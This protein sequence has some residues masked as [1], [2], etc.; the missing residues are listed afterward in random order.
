VASDR[1]AMPSDESGTT[2]SGVTAF[3][4]PSSTLGPVQPPGEAGPVDVTFTVHADRDAHPISPL[5]Y[6]TSDGRDGELQRW[7]VVRSGGNRLTAYNWEN[8]ASNAG[9]DYQFQNDS[10]MSVSDAPGRSLLDCIEVAARAGAPSI[11]TL[12]IGDYV[13]AD[14]NGG[15]DVRQAGPNYLA[16]RFKRNHAKKP[17][18]FAPT[19]NTTDGDVYQ[20]EAVAFLKRQR[21]EAKVIFA[22]DNEPD[23]WA[24]THAEVFPEPVTYADLWRRNHEF[25]KATK[26]AWPGVEVLGLVSYGYTGYIS[27]QNAPDAGGRNFLEWYLDQAKAAEAKDGRRLIDYLDLHWYPEAMG[28]GKRIVGDGVEPEVAEARVQAPRSLWDPTY[29]EASWIHDVVG[30]PVE[31]IPWIKKKIDGHYPDTKLAFTEWNFGGGSHISG[32][33]AT[34]D[35]LGVFGQQGVGLAAWWPMS[36]NEVFAHAAFRVFRNFDGG[37]SAFGDTSIAASSSDVEAATVYA[38]I[39]A[40]DVART[41]IVAINKSTSGKSAALLITHSAVYKTAKLYV[42]ADAGPRV[43]PMTTL[44]AVATNAFKYDMPPKS[45]TVIVPHQ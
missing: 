33:I 27:L 45:V 4:A 39:D 42:L 37:G 25:A 14:K 21:P 44:K 15:G 29:N 2:G 12:P 13:S 3:A 26:D 8:N 22:M 18:P 7:G 28:G 11:I 16:T 10:S 31:L 1:A 19:P 23:L 20:D 24:H 41:V 35:V 30:G 36:Q 34:A 40:K 9:S 38:S 43:F 17:T 5:I 32:A 6:G